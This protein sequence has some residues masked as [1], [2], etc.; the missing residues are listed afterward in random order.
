[1][2][3]EPVSIFVGVLVSLP[4]AFFASGSLV[5]HSAS[6]LATLRDGRSALVP[7]DT[8]FD[9]SHAVAVTMIEDSQAMILPDLLSLAILKVLKANQ[10]AP[11][12]VVQRTI[13]EYSSLRELAGP[14]ILDVKTLRVSSYPAILAN[15]ME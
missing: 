5:G 4:I 14:E 9:K 11:V 12:I 7:C 3:E 10:L 15:A 1:M 2:L 8:R 6:L 13:S